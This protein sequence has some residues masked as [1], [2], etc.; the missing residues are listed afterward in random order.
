L[1][2]SNDRFRLA[3][4]G[5]FDPAHKTLIPTVWNG[6]GRSYLETI[7]FNGEDHPA[8]PAV[9]TSR[10]TE[11]TVVSNIAD[12]LRAASWRKEAF[13]R[14]FQ[15]AISVPLSYGDR[16][17]GVL[18]VYADRPGEFDEM[19]VSVFAELG[20]TIAN[21]LNTVEMREALFT[22]RVVELE[23]RM[24]Y[25]TD[26][27]LPRLARRTDSFI[28]FEGVVPSTEK[29]LRVFF[30]VREGPG[31]E[32]LGVLQESSVVELG[33]LIVDRGDE[34]MLFEA[35]VSGRTIAATLVNNNA[36]L[37]TLTT[38]SDGIHVTVDKPDKA[39]VRDFIDRFQTEYPGLEFLAQR[40][41]EGPIETPEGFRTRLESSLT[42][43]QLEVLEMAYYSGFFESPRWKT[44]EE[45]GEALG[46]SQPTV[47]KHLRLAQRKLLSAVFDDN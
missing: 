44:G 22:D 2:T 23:F 43:P 8:E 30:T 9:R 14:E 12:D 16:S 4:I 26:S 5:E 29:G 19:M 28:E 34:G 39:D 18:T 37:R 11:V 42:D 40:R 15:S 36:S 25:E 10:T 13:S 24:P 35:V 21:A 47:T 31:D 32:I 17:F 46:I 1:L 20:H 7:T 41:R 38:T 6:L 3:W 45:I 27:F 33:R